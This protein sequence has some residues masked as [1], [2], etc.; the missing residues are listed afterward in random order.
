MVRP[1]NFAPQSRLAFVQILSIYRDGREGLK[2]VSKM[3]EKKWS[4]FPFETFRP[5]RQDYFF[6]SAP[7]L[8]KL[9]CWYDPKSRV[10]FTFQPDFPETFCYG[11]LRSRSSCCPVTRQ[12][13]AARETLVEVEEFSD[14]NGSLTFFLI[15][16]LFFCDFT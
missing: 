8:P 16:I 11:K 14:V 1:L 7:L 13:N 12:R 9:F 3:A 4:Q 6:K 15:F 10:P 5:E 2:L